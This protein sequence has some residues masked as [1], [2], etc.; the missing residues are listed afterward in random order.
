VYIFP[1]YYLLINR[2][3]LWD[4]GYRRNLNK[5]SYYISKQFKIKKKEEKKM[6]RKKRGEKGVDGD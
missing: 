3:K 5:K 6:R 2:E 4:V 1:L